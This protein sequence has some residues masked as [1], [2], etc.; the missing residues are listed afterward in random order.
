MWFKYTERFWWHANSPQRCLQVMSWLWVI[1]T[2][3]L[4]KYFGLGRRLKPL[5]MTDILI[6]LLMS[7][8]TSRGIYGS[9]WE[10]AC[11]GSTGVSTRTIWS[12]FA[13]ILWNTS[14]PKSSAT[15]SACVRCMTYKINCLHFLLR[16]R[17]KCQL[18]G[19]SITESSLLVIS[20][21]LIRTDSPKKW[22]MNWMTIH[23]TIVP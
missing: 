2:D 18:T 17:V 3:Y 9:N 15:P 12:M 5:G 13:M 19:T 16:E 10:S 8:S 21:L 6:L 7:A 4:R 23:R 14:K 20:D 11:G 22:G 1:W